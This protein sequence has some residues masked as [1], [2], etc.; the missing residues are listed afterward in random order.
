MSLGLVCNMR[1]IVQSMIAKFPPTRQCIS[2]TATR[3][4]RSTVASASTNN[5]NNIHNIRNRCT[6]MS[7]LMDDRL[8]TTQQHG[9][10]ARLSSYTGRINIHCRQFSSI[11]EKG[12]TDDTDESEVANEIEDADLMAEVQEANERYVVYRYDI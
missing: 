1:T 4:C 5:Y 11:Q 9:S 2:T 12:D 8:Q 7:C 10:T 6:V 3:R